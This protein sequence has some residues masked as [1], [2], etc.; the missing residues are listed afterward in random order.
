VTLCVVDASVSISWTFEDERTPYARSV[1]ESLRHERAVAPA[2]WPLELCNAVLTAIKRERIQQHDAT[3]LLAYLLELP[4]DVD[5]ATTFM[6]ITQEILTLGL[7]YRLS[8]Y[9]ASYLELAI[10]RGLPLATQDARLAAAAEGA[11]V[12]IL[13]P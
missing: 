11:G 5:Q 13:R 9:D 2:I 7:A 6:F 1:L 3:R 12:E 8:A 4:V 10:R